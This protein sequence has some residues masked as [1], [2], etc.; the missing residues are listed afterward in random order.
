MG[1]AKKLIGQNSFHGKDAMEKAIKNKVAK[2]VIPARDVMIQA[3]S[4]FGAKILPPKRI[5][6]MLPEL[7]DHQDQNVRA[8]S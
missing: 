6:K 2:A 1:R 5:L 8:S 7:F 3:L 4:E